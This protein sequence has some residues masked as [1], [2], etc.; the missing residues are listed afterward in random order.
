MIFK[1]S[2]QLA[3]THSKCSVSKSSQLCCE[4]AGCGGGIL[5]G[6]AGAR[7]W[8]WLD[9]LCSSS[10][11]IETHKQAACAIT[12]FSSVLLYLK[13]AQE[14]FFSRDCNFQSFLRC[15]SFYSCIFH[16][17]FSLILKYSIQSLREHTCIYS[18]F[19]CFC[20]T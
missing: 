9:C 16:R 1:S 17:L 8:S 14:F 12:V 7:L 5:A 19:L 18:L 15:V 6:Q 4:G 20:S 10:S 13:I 2:E 11:K 3:L